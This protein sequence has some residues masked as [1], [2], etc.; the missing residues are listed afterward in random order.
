MRSTLRFRLTTWYVAVLA[1]ILVIFSIG[2]YS[3]LRKNLLQ[4]LDST[5]RSAAQVS[6]MSLNHEI[7][8]H[9]G[10]TEGEAS[11]RSVLSTMHQTS[12][13]RT[14]ISIWEGHRLVAEKPG[15][16]G[17]PAESIRQYVEG[18]DLDNGFTTFTFAGKP[19]R[20]VWTEA[21]V[22]QVST[23][24]QVAAVESMEPVLAELA[25]LREILWI[26]IPLC[27]LLAAVGGY[28]LARKSVAPMFAMAKTADQISSRSLNRRLDVINP[29][30]E[31]GY[32]AATFNRLFARLEE[33]F[34]QQRRFM[35]DASHELRTPL[36]VALT[37]TQVSLTSPSGDGNS[38]ERTD[39]LTV[40]QQQLLR[41]RRVVEDMFMLAQ[42]EN[43]NYSPAITTFYLSEVV[44][45]SV[46]AAQVLGTVRQVH[47]R[48]LPPVSEIQYVG[49]EGLLRQLFLILLDNAVKYSPPGGHVYVRE[50]RQQDRVIVTIQDEGCGVPESAQSHI[51][52]RFFRVD[53]A[54]SRNIDG[55]GSGAGL[56]LAIAQWIAS[57]HA[58]VVRLDSSTSAG[59]SFSVELPLSPDFSRAAPRGVH[60]TG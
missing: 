10:K 20:V 43:G 23:R 35:T 41:L 3:L 60:I 38:D 31:L 28:F 4:R 21:F 50:A 25:T 29:N 18:P 40:I 12:F 26:T 34:D 6:T 56:G 9:G 46:R 57:L 8:E 42:A 44:D 22:S 27:L 14:A 58:G 24:Y 1:A 30:D 7:E 54:R 16:N 37:A 15:T 36:S 49:D 39:A 53:K 32:L 19:Y 55:F 11:V 59:S 47:V 2:V 52:E 51:F 5:L 48:R 13:P 45:E 17:S 33:A